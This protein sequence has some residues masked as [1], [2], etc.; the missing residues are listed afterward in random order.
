MGFFF[1]LLQIQYYE[2][3]LTVNFDPYRRTGILKLREKKASLGCTW[4]PLFFFFLQIRHYD[5][6]QIYLQKNIYVPI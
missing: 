5:N 3:Y 6:V 4:N 2:N 1:F